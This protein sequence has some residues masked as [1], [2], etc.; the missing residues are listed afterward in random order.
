M[1]EP[2]FRTVNPLLGARPSYGPIP[3]DLLL[4]WGV[5]SLLLFILSHSVLQL[6]MQWTIAL[7]FWGD[8]SWWVLTGSKPY[9]FLSKFVPA[10]N[11]W[12]RGYVR[13]KPLRAM[14]KI[15]ED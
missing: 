3:A 5:I 10:P 12:S 13:Y 15:R 1:S 7:I 11:R 14:K 6:Q 2:K 4:P 8:A 9:R